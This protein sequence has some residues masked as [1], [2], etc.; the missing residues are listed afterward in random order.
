M[1]GDA[2]ERRKRPRYRSRPDAAGK[3]KCPL[4]PDVLAAIPE[5]DVIPIDSKRKRHAG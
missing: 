1:E 3:V 4:P 5:A 2:D